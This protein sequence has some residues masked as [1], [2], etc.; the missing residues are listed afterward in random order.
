MVNDID[1]YDDD[2][3]VWV[4]IKGGDVC[5]RATHF[6]IRSIRHFGVEYFTNYSSLPFSF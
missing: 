3:C 5:K 6:W 4:D 1:V 2:E